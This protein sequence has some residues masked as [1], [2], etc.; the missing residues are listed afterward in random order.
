[1]AK[2]TFKINCT[3]DMEITVDYQDTLE[4]CKDV[5][6]DTTDLSALM[7]NQEYYIDRY[8]IN[9]IKL[10]KVLEAN[11]IVAINKIEYYKEEDIEHQH[12]RVRNFSQNPKIQVITDVDVDQSE[13][14]CYDEI[15]AAIIDTLEEENLELYDIVSVDYTILKEY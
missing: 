13:H 12:K 10:S 2:A 15:E 14:H 9:E 4:D 11:Y 7:Q 3:L 6:R 5:I 1:M 8:H